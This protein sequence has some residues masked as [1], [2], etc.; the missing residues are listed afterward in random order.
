MNL[1]KYFPIIIASIVFIIFL[2]IH[3]TV[4]NTPIDKEAGIIAEEVIKEETG[5]DIDLKEV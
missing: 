5:I 1:A 2:Y 4:P 3:Y